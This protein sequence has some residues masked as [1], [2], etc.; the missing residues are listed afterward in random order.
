MTT[1]IHN[2][3]T[4]KQTSTH[5]QHAQQAVGYIKWG[6]KQVEEKKN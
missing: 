2:K 4:N 1:D 3:Q 5:T 6:K